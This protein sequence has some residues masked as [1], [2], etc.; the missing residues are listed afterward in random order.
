MKNSNEPPSYVMGCVVDVVMGTPTEPIVQVT[1]V[2]MVAKSI[3]YRL[4][5]KNMAFGHDRKY[6][7]FWNYYENFVNISQRFTSTKA[8]H[9]HVTMVQGKSKG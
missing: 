1:R 5:V 3:L 8:F 6:C 4:P 2:P 7:A 9:T